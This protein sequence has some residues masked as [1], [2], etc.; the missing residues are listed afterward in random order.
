MWRFISSHSAFDQKLRT[1]SQLSIYLPTSLVGKRW[2]PSRLK[3]DFVGP[4]PPKGPDRERKLPLFCWY[5]TLFLGME[6]TRAPKKQK[7]DTDYEFVCVS[8]SKAFK[9]PTLTEAFAKVC[10]CVTEELA[11][12][13]MGITKARTDRCMRM[14]IYGQFLGCRDDQHWVHFFRQRLI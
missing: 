7:T 1:S 2:E 9:C 8:F 10:S 14:P 3:R 12:F 4:T 13:C 6:H 11:Q 5:I